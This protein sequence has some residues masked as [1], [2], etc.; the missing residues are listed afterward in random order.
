MSPLQVHKGKVFPPLL[1]KRE[2]K[3]EWC[4]AKSIVRS[5]RYPV[6]RMKELWE[7]LTIHHGD[8]LPNLIKL[9]QIAM[10]LPLHTADC[11]RTFSAQN[12]ILTKLRNRLAPEV[13]DKLLRIRIHGKGL[14]VHDFQKTLTIW[15]QQKKRFLKTG[16]AVTRAVTLM[17]Q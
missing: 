16:S 3:R 11:E 8:E 12:L 2:V 13:S 17:S 4:R 15:H 10:C 6:D 14:Q 5:L 1:S 9:A 7:L